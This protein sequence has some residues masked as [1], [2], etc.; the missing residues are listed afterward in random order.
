[1][2]RNTI[3]HC[4]DAADAARQIGVSSVDAKQSIQTGA[5]QPFG[6]RSYRVMETPDND[7]LKAQ[8]PVILEIDNSPQLPDAA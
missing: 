1:M 7:P 6:P 3:V 2:R 4:M 5:W 8:M